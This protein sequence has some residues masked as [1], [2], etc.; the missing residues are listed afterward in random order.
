[1]PLNWLGTVYREI[2]QSIIDMEVLAA[3][4][5]QLKSHPQ[6]LPNEEGTT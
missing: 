3:V 4:L 5:S 1:V 6:T 2:N